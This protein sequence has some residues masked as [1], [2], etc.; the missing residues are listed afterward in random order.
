MNSFSLRNQSLNK[1]RKDQGQ[2]LGEVSCQREKGGEMEEQ[3]GQELLE[4]VREGHSNKMWLGGNGAM[5][6]KGEGFGK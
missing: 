2:S 1:D 4:L 3:R 6:S 5:E